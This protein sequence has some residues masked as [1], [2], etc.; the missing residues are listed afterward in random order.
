MDKLRV[1]PQNDPHRRGLRVCRDG[2]G[3]VD[4]DNRD[5]FEYTWY[6]YLHSILVI[7]LDSQQL[8]DSIHPFIHCVRQAPTYGRTIVAT[9]SGVLVRNGFFRG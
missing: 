4:Q 2:H 6:R 1:T 8:R 5:T 7:P 9:T 3:I